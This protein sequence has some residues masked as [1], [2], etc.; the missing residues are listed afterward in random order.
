MNSLKALLGSAAVA[1]FPAIAAA[2]APITITGH[3]TAEHG[4]TLGNVTV[5]LAEL[6][7]G[8]VTRDDGSYSLR[9]P[10][11]RIAGQTVTLSARRVGYKPKSA[12]FTLGSTD[13]VQDFDIEANPL[14]LGEV[15]ITGAG[16][17]SVVEKI[18][19]VGKSVSPDLIV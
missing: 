8:A 15:V 5:S 6:G 13:L 3:V 19:N 16:K 11:A 12:R 9:V 1:L 10:G 18:G 14:Q 17:W 4:A 2:Q 7:L